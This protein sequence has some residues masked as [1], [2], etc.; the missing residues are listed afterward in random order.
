MTVTKANADVLDLTDA[1]AFSG[2]VSGTSKIVQVVYTQST[3]NTTGTTL[4]PLDTSIPQNNE[5]TE[6]LTLAITPTNT[7]NIL[8]IDIDVK[9]GRDASSGWVT[10][11]LHQDSTAAAI[12]SRSIYGNSVNEVSAGTAWTYFMEA[13]TVSETTFK[14]RAGPN[15]SQTI[16][17]NGDAGTNYLTGNQPSTI[18]VTEIAV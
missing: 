5:G 2:T 9:V 10:Q 1:Y 7:S 11:A 8:R 12:S 17:M 6:L 14:L 15:N 13:G 4:T 16:R 18:T 3:A